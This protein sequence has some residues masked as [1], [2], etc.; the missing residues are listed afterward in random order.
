MSSD[1][2]TTSVVEKVFRILAWTQLLR[3]LVRSFISFW[4][5]KICLKTS[6]SELFSFWS[7]ASEPTAMNFGS[8]M[9]DRYIR[10]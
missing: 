7:I 3:G 9:L 1:G 5:E 10:S 2:P 6:E 4:S 8:L